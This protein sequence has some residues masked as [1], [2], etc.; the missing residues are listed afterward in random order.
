MNEQAKRELDKIVILNQAKRETFSTLVK[1]DVEHK[2]SL[3]TF[4]DS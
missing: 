1:S 2:K 4:D 3:K